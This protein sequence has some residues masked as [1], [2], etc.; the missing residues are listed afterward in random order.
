MLMQM[1][2]TGSSHSDDSKAMTPWWESLILAAALQPC[3]RPLL[4][5]TLCLSADV[6]LCAD[7]V[8]DM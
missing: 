6:A 7:E 1:R 5:A 8:V 2:G 3:L 4:S